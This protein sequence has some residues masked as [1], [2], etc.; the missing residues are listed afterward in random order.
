MK[1][2]QKSA[3]AKSEDTKSVHTAKKSEKKPET[4]PKK[5]K[6]S[7]MAGPKTKVETNTN[8]GPDAKELKEL[9]A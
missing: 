4:L 3:T 7:V 8:D 6:K 2:Q 1:S 9:A 5:K